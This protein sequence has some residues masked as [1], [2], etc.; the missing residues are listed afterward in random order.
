[1]NKKSS[2][3][4]TI[5]QSWVNDDVPE[6]DIRHNANGSEFIPIQ[7]IEGLL[8]RLDVCWGTE[9]FK[10][11]VFN[12]HEQTFASG[13]LELVVM[14]FGKLRRI[15][16]AA[17]FEIFGGENVEAITKSECIKNGSKILGKRMGRDLNNRDDTLVRETTSPTI[18]KNG[19]QKP[20]AVKMHPDKYIREAYAK[21]VA[22]NDTN[23]ISTLENAYDFTL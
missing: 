9:N 15:I 22:N 8:S 3:T 19:K 16:G 23:I 21:A 1:M 12:I 13:S 18:K 14:F 5:D 20:P 6:D 11:R 7:I 2:A 17:T 4:T 10:F